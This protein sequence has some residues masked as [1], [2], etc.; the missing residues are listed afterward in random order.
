MSISA[1]YNLP[2]EMIKKTQKIYWDAL[3]HAFKMATP[4]MYPW[5]NFVDVTALTVPI[6]NSSRI[7]D[8]QGYD[9]V[10]EYEQVKNEQV[11][12][13]WPVQTAA[14]TFRKALPITK[15]MISDA[16]FDPIYRFSAQ[17]GAGYIKTLDQIVAN[18]F[19][20]GA[21]TAGHSVFKN[22]YGP[23]RP[24]PTGKFIY[25][26]RPLF[27]DSS[28]PH[29]HK[30]NTG[31]PA[32]INLSQL[33]LDHPNLRTAYI[34][35]TTDNAVNDD[36]TPLAVRPTIL[37]TARDLALDSKELLSAKYLP[38]KQTT[39]SI[40]NEV[41]SGLTPVSW[42]SL[43]HPSSWYLVQPKAGL[44][45]RIHSLPRLEIENNPS[46]NSVSLFITCR[47]GLT[48]DNWRGV[49]ANKVPTIIS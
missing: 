47:M 31:K 7:L 22:D 27:A 2:S 30:Y 33:P 9:E 23:D 16:D 34:Q 10:D 37:L 49:Y 1:K 8:G 44:A 6:E 43:I 45:L 3:G 42:P 20:Y 48:V 15:N 12:Y 35:M 40:L 28:N 39:P 46:T 17:L 4:E 36:G 26:G 13:G 29:P 24:D 19:N 5:I 18:A 14:K 41:G 11:L 25:D 32:G 21:L 38:H